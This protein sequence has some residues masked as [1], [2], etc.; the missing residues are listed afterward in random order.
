[1]LFKNF[2]KIKVPEFDFNKKNIKKEEKKP[3][4]KWMNI[5]SAFIGIQVLFFGYNTF[6]LTNNTYVKSEEILKVFPLFQEVRQDLKK[7]NDEKAINDFIKLKSSSFAITDLLASTIITSVYIDDTIEP[8]KRDEYSFNVKP[9][10]KK[11]LLSIYQNNLN[12]G[13]NKEKQ[14]LENMQC[15]LIDFSCHLFKPIWVNELKKITSNMEDKLNIANYNISHPEE[16]K[17]WQKNISVKLEK[18]NQPSEELRTPGHIY[19]K[20]K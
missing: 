11:L 17:A 20:V 9:E 6:L 2:N 16:F 4:F 8:N 12:S 7:G 13:L 10:T 5:L 14:D 18:G 19:Y 15:F 3:S 1:M